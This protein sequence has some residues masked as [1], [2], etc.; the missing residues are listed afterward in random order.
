[1]RES[2]CIGARRLVPLLAKRDARSAWPPA[3]TAL[4]ANHAAQVVETALLPPAIGVESRSS[5][6]D[7]LQ[8]LSSTRPS[9]NRGAFFARFLSDR[10]R[11]DL[12]HPSGLCP[13]FALRQ[14]RTTPMHSKPD[15]S[16]PAASSPCAGAHP[17][18]EELSAR[19]NSVMETV[20]ELL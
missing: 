3:A 2:R 4:A 8:R 7:K 9:F 13:N 1:M 14:V 5:T 18:G 6:S 10:L 19:K 20:L 16:P 12:R 17:T 11:P 15:N